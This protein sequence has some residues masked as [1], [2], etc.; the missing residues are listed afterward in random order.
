MNNEY[1]N[2]HKP[3]H[4]STFNIL[5]IMHPIRFVNQQKLSALKGQQMNNQGQRPWKKDTAENRLT[6]KTHQ[7]P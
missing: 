4:H 7:D 5:F 1:R 3:L 2:V 6:R